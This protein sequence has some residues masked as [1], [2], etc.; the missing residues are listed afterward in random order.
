MRTTE[1]YTGEGIIC[2]ADNDSIKRI[3]SDL[4]LEKRKENKK[5]QKSE[6]NTKRFMV[7]ANN[8]F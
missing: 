7:L 5:K 4:Q 8:K 6:E 1:M 2:V 3:I